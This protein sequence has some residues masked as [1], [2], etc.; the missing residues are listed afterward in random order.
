MIDTSMR[1]AVERL[2]GPTPTAGGILAA[3]AYHQRLM[4]VLNTRP[5]PLPR[6]VR[7]AL[8]KRERKW[9]ARAEG[10]DK[11]WLAVGSQPGRLARFLEAELSPLDPT[12]HQPVRAEDFTG[13][14]RKS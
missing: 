10:S 5:S 6:P 4:A 3:R 13:G 2:V 1:A 9:R 11:R 8:Q 7:H 12:Y 14:R